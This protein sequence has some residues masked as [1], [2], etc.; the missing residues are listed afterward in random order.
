VLADTEL[1][2]GR[3]LSE[4]QVR[5]GEYERTS[6]GSGIERWFQRTANSPDGSTNVDWA[7]SEDCPGALEA[8][9]AVR[10]V[11][12]PGLTEPEWAE[13]VQSLWSPIYIE[14]TIYTLETEAWFSDGHTAR[15]AITGPSPSP[16][17]RWSV[18]M[19]AVLEECWSDSVPEIPPQQ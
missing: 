3:L 6:G 1:I 12:V 17:G 11:E 8:F 7:D 19:L 2:I 15:I 10:S 4:D 16:I 5:S 18:A 14:G 9:E 13:E